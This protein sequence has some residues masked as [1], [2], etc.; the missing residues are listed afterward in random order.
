MTMPVTVTALFAHA[1]MATVLMLARVVVTVTD[2]LPCIVA[3]VKVLDEINTGANF[4]TIS[5]DGAL[6]VHA[7]F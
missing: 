5:T 1:A 7:R 3:V 2:G 4:A 6:G